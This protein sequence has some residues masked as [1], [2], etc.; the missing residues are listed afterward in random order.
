LCP[1]KPRCDWLLERWA[2]FKSLWRRLP[3]N[4]SCSSALTALAALTAA[5]LTLAAAALALAAS[6][7]PTALWGRQWH[8]SCFIEHLLARRTSD[9]PLLFILLWRCAMHQKCLRLYVDSCYI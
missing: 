9:K 6:D 3:E 8:N 2:L 4:A 7:N 5:A 1:Y